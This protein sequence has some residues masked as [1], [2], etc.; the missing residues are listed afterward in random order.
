[1]PRAGLDEVAT[2]QAEVAAELGA[3]FRVALFWRSGFAPSKRTFYRLKNSLVL[4]SFRRRPRML[5]FDHGFLVSLVVLVS[6]SRI[7][8]HF[9]L[10]VLGGKGGYAVWHFVLVVMSLLEANFEA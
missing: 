8:G 7:D 4:K 10:V 3:T 6:G 9:Q 5:S 2:A 1:M